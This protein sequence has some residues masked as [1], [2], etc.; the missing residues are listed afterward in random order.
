MATL[1]Q[2]NFEIDNFVKKLVPEEIVLFQKKIA[3]E[4]LRK[5]VKRTPVD[6]G[7]ARGNWQVTSNSF[8]TE[9]LP[10]DGGSSRQ[11]VSD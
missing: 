8:P 3:L 7:R 9:P 11:V 5:L 2:F 1:R 10:G 4:A 6:T